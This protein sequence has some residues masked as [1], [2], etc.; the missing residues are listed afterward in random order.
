VADFVA[1]NLVIVAANISAQLGTGFDS[2]AARLRARDVISRRESVVWT[3]SWRILVLI[4]SLPIIYLVCL[5]D[6]V[7]RSTSISLLTLVAASISACAFIAVSLCLIEAQAR[8]LARQ[9]GVRQLAYYLPFSGAL[10]VAGAIGSLVGALVCLSVAGVGSLAFSLKRWGGATAL[11]ARGMEFGNKE[12]RRLGL[13]IFWTGACYALVDKVD[14][15]MAARYF[16]S[17][18]A[19][20]IA[21]GTRLTAVLALA[22]SALQTMNISSLGKPRNRKE[23]N[24]AYVAQWP[25]FAAFAGLVVVL[26]FIGSAAA[27]SIFGDKYAI[28][29]LPMFLLSAPFFFYALYSPYAFALASMGARR[30]LVLA[31]GVQGGIKGLVVVLASSLGSPVLL[32]ASGLLGAAAAAVAVALYR[33]EDLDRQVTHV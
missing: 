4:G 2:A 12:Y 13:V 15:I 31:I 11:T 25:I 9:F 18:V 5:S 3:R 29:M 17:E 26:S 19:S 14:V 27:S 20:T 22:V 28:G 10:V 30:T 24:K 7:P 23:L 33:L 16:N 32:Y 1:I 8:G 6:P 21:I